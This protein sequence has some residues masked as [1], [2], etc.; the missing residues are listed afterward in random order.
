MGRVLLS[1]A[2]SDNTGG[3]GIQADIK[4]ADHF[5]VFACTAITAVTAQN[6]RGVAGS[7]YVGDDL[8]RMQIELANEQMPPDAVKIGLIPTASAASVIGETLSG[9]LTKHIVADPV[10]VA[11]SGTDMTE[12]A[13]KL[14]DAYCE[15][16][17]PRISLLTPNYPEFLKFCYKYS[18][19]TP[20]ESPSEDKLISSTIQLMQASGLHALLLKGGHINPDNRESNLNNDDMG[21]D[22]NKSSE[23]NSVQ[24]STDYLF[25][26]IDREPALT[27]RFSMPRINTPHSHGTGCALSSAIACALANGLCLKEAVR[28]AKQYINKALQNGALYPVA[29]EKGPLYFW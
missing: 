1:I 19:D 21:C 5:R 4:T 13:D 7:I 14:L 26:R 3:A 8:L 12:G 18:I 9:L 16:I 29:R 2:G 15:A 10:M 17:I 22:N 20:E 27:A 25:E 23:D 24:L 11:S 6:H 28:E